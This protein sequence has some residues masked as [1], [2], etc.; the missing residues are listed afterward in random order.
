M[1]KQ[2]LEEI[3]KADN[4]ELDAIAKK[5]NVISVFKIT[6]KKKKDTATAYFKKPDRNVMGVSISLQKTS[7]LRAKEVI[8][9]TCFLEGDNRILSDDD[10][11]YSACTIMDE[12]I[13]IEE[14]DLKKNY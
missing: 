13:S 9:K 6:A 14:G 7:V 2:T 8:L 11:F 5:H 12:I 1:K 3:E 10:F 4:A